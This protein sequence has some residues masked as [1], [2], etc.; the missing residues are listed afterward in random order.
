[1]QLRDQST[2]PR[3][4]IYQLDDQGNPTNLIKSQ[5]YDPRQ[6]P[7]YKA[8]VAG[9]QPTWTEVYSLRQLRVIWEL[10]QSTQILLIPMEE[11]GPL[12]RVVVVLHQLFLRNYQLPLKI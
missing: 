11:V 7:W 8:A 12:R 5:E 4:N 6:R 1:M 10:T 2:A 3:R 9:S